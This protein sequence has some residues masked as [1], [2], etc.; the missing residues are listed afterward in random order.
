M[1]DIDI[2]NLIALEKSKLV[3]GQRIIKI[4]SNIFLPV[5]LGGNTP[6]NRQTNVLFQGKETKML[7]ETS[8]SYFSGNISTNN[9][10]DIKM[11]V[12]TPVVYLVGEYK[13]EDKIFVNSK[14]FETSYLILS[15]S[16]NIKVNGEYFLTDDELTGDNRIWSNGDYYICKS[17]DTDGWCVT[18]NPEHNTLESYLYF[19]NIDTDNPYSQTGS[20]AWGSVDWNEG[21]LINNKQ[22]LIFA[23]GTSSSVDTEDFSM[24]SSILAEGDK[25]IAVIDGRTFTKVNSGF[26]LAGYYY[27]GEHTG[28]LLV[29]KTSASA[30]IKNNSTNTVLDTPSPIYYSISTKEISETE[31]EGFEKFYWNGGTSYWMGGNKNASSSDAPSIRKLKDGQTVLNAL[32]E[33]LDRYFSNFIFFPAYEEFDNTERYS[34][35]NAGIAEV[36]SNNYH[37]VGK[38]DE[39]F[40]DVLK[41]SYTINYCYTNG[42][43]FLCG[44]TNQ[45]L[46]QQNVIVPIDWDGETDPPYFSFDNV[47]KPTE[48]TN[49][50]YSETEQKPVIAIN[51]TPNILGVNGEIVAPDGVN[52]TYN[53]FDPEKFGTER[54]WRTEDGAY[55]ITYTQ[56]DGKWVISTRENPTNIADALFYINAENVE[57]PYIDTEN[58]HTWT[59]VNSDA[60][61]VNGEVTVIVGGL[62]EPPYKEF[63]IFN[64]PDNNVNGYYRSVD[65]EK[66]TELYNQMMSVWNF[67]WSDDTL[68]EYYAFAKVDGDM[69]CFAFNNQMVVFIR[70]EYLNKQYWDSYSAEGS[71]TDWNILPRNFEDKY[72]YGGTYTINRSWVDGEL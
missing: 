23:N 61:T 38:D 32:K 27:N 16:S 4:G 56:E 35:S 14:I 12:E 9:D 34:I 28:P 62:A 20:L 71:G 39:N 36:N 24:K 31:T 22:F 13:N 53:L 37:I 58:S 54:K 43:Y 29:G 63:S 70:K 25:I 17:A 51:T 66:D 1:A 8:F 45:D 50:N 46:M 48:I 55:Y 18:D 11:A 67:H 52:A 57:N 26:A 15:G 40:P 2:N 69:V 47:L 44:Y 41:N 3:K 65:L 42:K 59:I 19:T 72:M 33:L 7:D 21:S 60:V 68:S 49:W 64:L 6:P 5:G 30:E 10:A